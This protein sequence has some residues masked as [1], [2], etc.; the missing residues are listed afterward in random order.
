[1]CLSNLRQCYL[2]FANYAS[3]WRGAIL[4][5]GEGRGPN[6][7]GW[8]DGGRKTQ[9]TEF[10][11]Y[12]DL[13][14]DAQGFNPQGKVWIDRRIT[15]CPANQ[16]YATDSVA[17]SGSQLDPYLRWPGYGLYCVTP[18]KWDDNKEIAKATWHTY[19]QGGINGTY[20]PAIV[21]TWPTIWQQIV[22][23]QYPYK[24]PQASDTV[25]MADTAETFSDT[26]HMGS[27]F[28]CATIP[29]P[30][31]NNGIDYAYIQTS[32][33]A[34]PGSL[35]N[36]LFYDGHAASLTAKALRYETASRIQATIDLNGTATVFPAPSAPY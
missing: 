14:W 29:G 23:L 28:N 27:Y 12:A 15:L 30:G 10:L 4:V 6:G 2:A 5:M 9:W 32:H 20:C 16:F 13:G 25:M 11:C 33:G 18:A 36:V 17:A 22:Y 3:E 34:L 31:S 35:A 19:R 24:V 21:W 8:S 7:S 1:V 26:G